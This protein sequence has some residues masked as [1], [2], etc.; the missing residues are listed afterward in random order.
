MFGGGS[1]CGPG[2]SPRGEK[3]K[4]INFYGACPDLLVIVNLARLFTFLKKHRTFI[5]GP[6]FVLHFKKIEM[7]GRRMP[8]WIRIKISDYYNNAAGEQEY[9][10]VS[11]EVYEA[12]AND[13]RKEAEAERKRDERNRASIN[14]E[15]GET[16]DLLFIQQESLEEVVMRELETQNLQTAM[17]ELTDVQKE[18]LQLYFFEGKTYRE[19][20]EKQKVSDYSVRE[21]ISGALKKIKKY[22]D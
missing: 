17:Q 2:N 5:R 21:S 6:P 4:F 15:D 7:E 18:R 14:Y 10:Y 19:I 20:A 22:F 9:T 13:F 16:D 12:L 8:E 3:N 11:P 1:V